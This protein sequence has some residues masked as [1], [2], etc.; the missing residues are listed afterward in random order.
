M[1]P[2]VVHVCRG[3]WSGPYSACL[4]NA[5]ECGVHSYSAA[6]NTMVH[7]SLVQELGG[8]DHS[9][10]PRE[11]QTVLHQSVARPCCPQR[12]QIRRVVKGEVM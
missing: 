3:V 11:D 5:E 7:D 1:D 4:H 6:G 8:C 9:R 10:S 2:T 12:S